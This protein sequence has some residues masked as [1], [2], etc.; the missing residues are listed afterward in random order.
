MATRRARK[1]RLPRDKKKVDPPVSTDWLIRI[2]MKMEATKV[3]SGL[4]PCFWM[5]IPRSAGVITQAGFYPCHI[6]ERDERLWYGFC[7][8]E[9]RNAFFDRME[10]A[11]KEYTESA[12]V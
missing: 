5:S 4:R 6:F 12:H 2:G 7:F 3:L 11:R 1:Q 8:L 9:H 10:G